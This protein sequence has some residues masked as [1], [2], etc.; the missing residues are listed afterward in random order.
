MPE[1]N[2]SANNLNNVN[3]P[4][5][6]L[7]N[8]AFE[9]PEKNLNSFVPESPQTP[10]NS[11]DSVGM[12]PQNTFDSAPSKDAGFQSSFSNEMMYENERNTPNLKKI[13]TIFGA[14]FLFLSLSAGG[15]VLIKGKQAPVDDQKVEEVQ[16]EV[17]TE[18]D[19]EE[20]KKED[21]KA[22]D[23]PSAPSQEQPKIEIPQPEMQT[24]DETGAVKGTG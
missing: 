13:L 17:F 11:V 3:D 21:V 14:I 7:S 6:D 19:E 15:Y 9:N 24:P 23:E 1:E 4:K 2:N 18:E 16:E 8:T 10:A 12:N 22:S 5:I 20:G